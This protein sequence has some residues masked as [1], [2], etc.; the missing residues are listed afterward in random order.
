[1]TSR[2]PTEAEQTI[3]TA[4][5]TEERDRYSS[6]PD[7]VTELLAVGDHQHPA[8]LDRVELAAWTV[9]ALTLL[10]HDEVVRRQ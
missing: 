1:L 10:S 8:E 7:S 6:Q 2:H 5:F 9:V 3:V 4:F